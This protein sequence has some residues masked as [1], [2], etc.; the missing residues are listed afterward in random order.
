MDPDPEEREISPDPVKWSDRIRICSTASKALSICDLPFLYSA[1]LP[2]QYSGD[3]DIQY[4][5]GG[6]PTVPRVCSDA[7]CSRPQLVC[8]VWLRCVG[9]KGSELYCSLKHTCTYFSPEIKGSF[10]WNSVITVMLPLCSHAP[11]SCPST[12]GRVGAKIFSWIFP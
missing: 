2:V 12:R 11:L 3:T 4:S 5:W 8:I 7:L 1:F 10:E 9:G 6:L